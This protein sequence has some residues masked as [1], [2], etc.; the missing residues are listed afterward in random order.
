MRARAAARE[1]KPAVQKLTQA[2]PME[3]TRTGA[4]LAAIVEETIHEL[5]QASATATAKVLVAM[6]ARGV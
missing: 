3:L 2:Q 1:V 6:A 5:T 4:A